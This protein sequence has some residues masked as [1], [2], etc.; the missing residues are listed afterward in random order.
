MS[1]LLSATLP[2][3]SLS[4]EEEQRAPAAAEAALAVALASGED[5][6]PLLVGEVCKCFEE[7]VG[8]GGRALGAARLMEAYAR[9]KKVD[10]TEVVD[11]LIKVRGWGGM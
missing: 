9:S 4:E 11:D 2:L 3:S 1:A 6:L 8:P 5:G 7:G 10:L